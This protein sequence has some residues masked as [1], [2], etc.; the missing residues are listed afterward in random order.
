MRQWKVQ[1][2]HEQPLTL[3]EASQRELE[4]GEVRIRMHATSLNFRDQLLLTGRYPTGNGEPV[5]PLSDGAGEVIA[6]SQGVSRVKAGDRVTATTI[7]NWVDGRFHR[8]MAAGSIGFTVDGWLSEEVVLPETALVVIPDALSYAAA[9]TLPCAGVTAWNAVIETAHIAPGDSVLALGT[10]GV[11]MF[12]IQ[13]ARLVSAQALV[14]SSSDDKLERA[15]YHGADLGVNYRTHP[16]WVTR[17]VELT[18]GEGVDLVIEN[19]G[20]LRQSVQA[21]RYGGMVAVIGMLAAL[22]PGQ[23]RPDGDLSDLLRFGVTVTPMMMGNRRMLSRM[24]DA[25]VRHHIE[26]VIDRTFPF[27]EAPAAFQALSDAQHVGK[28]VITNT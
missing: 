3:V 19:A 23:A 5:V 22:S 11:S 27:D 15:Y 7:T 28:I 16:D 18:N 2:K 26:P 12:A 6:I 25:F 17:V 4:P 20:T 13:I 10:G 24:I 14:I 1:P 9:A 8:S 21:T